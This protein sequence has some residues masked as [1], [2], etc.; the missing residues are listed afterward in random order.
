MISTFHFYVVFNPLIKPVSDYPTQAHEFYHTLKNNMSHLWWGKIKK[1][2]SLESLNVGNFQEVIEQN[3]KDGAE[4]VLFISD[5]THLWI[6]KVEEATTDRPPKNETLSVYD[7]E[8]V[9]IWFKVT[10]MD[11]IC[12]DSQSTRVKISELGIKNHFYPGTDVK[13]LSPQTGAIRFPL[14]VEDRA[15]EQYFTKYKNKKRMVTGNAY[16]VDKSMEGWENREKVTYTIP[17]K[18]FKKL[19]ALLQKQIMWAEGVFAQDMNKTA[20]SYLRILESVL[21]VTLMRE[22]HARVNAGNEYLPLPEVYSVLNLGKYNGQNVD[23]L[24]R[25]SVHAKFWEFCKIDLR[26][27]L[28]MPVNGKKI[29]MLEPGEQMKTEAALFVRNSMLG[30][31]CK[32]I[33]NEIIERYEEIAKLTLEEDQ[34]AS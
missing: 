7:G 31:G 17:H 10:D 22:I 19:P 21:N 18:N 30:V 8:D 11:L 33:I 20:T 23:E 3:K 4:T 28:H 2:A 14:I 5:F 13:V 9:E 32:G 6:A 29:C 27:F 1:T 26:N 15:T 34:A 25:N 16:L 12:A 24:L